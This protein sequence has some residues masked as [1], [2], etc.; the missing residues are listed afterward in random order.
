[1]K[2]EI[3]ENKVVVLSGAG[4]SAES[5]IQTFRD[6]DGL[7]ENYSINEVAT[8]RGWRENPDLVLAFYNE[9]RSQISE[10]EP[11][12]AHKAIAQLQ[13]K[14]ETVVITQN[15][16][17]LHE[18]AGS[19]NVIHVH[20]EITK[21]RSTSHPDVVTEI[22]Y[23]PISIG[24]SCEFGSQLRPHIVWFGEEVHNYELCRE[25]IRTAKRVLIVG[26]SLAV[27]PVAGLLKKARYKAEKIIVSLDIEKK[28]FGYQFIRGKA[29]E[30]VPYICNCWLDGRAAI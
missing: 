18:R 19:K 9:R 6:S 30:M 24:D 3:D 4:I 14:Y 16:D 1:M 5:G 7:W 27:Y 23:K 10:V 26:T 25:H 28:P 17:D 2:K 11:N 13:E 15:I 22:G 12:K 20:G 29:S 8:P 21:A